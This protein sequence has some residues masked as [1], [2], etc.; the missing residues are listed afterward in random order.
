[1]RHHVSTRT[2]AGRPRRFESVLVGIVAIV[3]SPPQDAPTDMAYARM[4]AHSGVE[5]VLELRGRVGF[6]AFHGGSLEAVT[7]LVATAAADASGAS[8]YCVRQPPDLRWHIPSTAVSPRASGRLARFL[9]HVEVAVAIH[10]YGRSGYWTTLL[11]GGANRAL[12]AH[13]AGYVR[14]ALD[15]Y[16]VVEDLERIPVR[17]RGVHPDNPVNLPAHG[18]MQLELPPRV[19]GIGPFWDGHP[20][21]CAGRLA[22]DTEVLI[23][24]LATAA[25]AWPAG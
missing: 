25:R 21:R 13:V 6:M 16:E 14:S 10:G 4:L 8:L 24:A 20:F 12:A 19:R 7:D 23:E 22:P 9:D 2:V 1:M 3:T 15:G 5:E 17:L 11:A 18:G